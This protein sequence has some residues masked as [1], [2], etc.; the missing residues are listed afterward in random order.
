MIRLRVLGELTLQ[1]DDDAVLDE[2][3][4]QPKRVA[5]LVYLALR[6]GEFH[7]RDTLLCLFWPELD[8]KHARAALNQA[9]LF[10][11]RE[12]DDARHEVLASRGNDEVGIDAG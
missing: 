6:P 10:L 3:L 11:R 9:L 1:R 12:L 2:A 7:R 4:A 8:E 5:L